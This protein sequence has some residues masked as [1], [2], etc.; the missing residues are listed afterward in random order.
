MLRPALISALALTA[1]LSGC[2]G[3]GGQGEPAPK[4]TSD[5][6]V[7]TAA[8]TD[9]LAAVPAAATLTARTVA[10]ADADLL[11]IYRK[12]HAAPE[13]SFEEAKTSA[14]LAQQM[15]SMGFE[16]TTGLGEDWVKAKATKDVGKV[17]PGVGGYGVVAVLRNGD[18]PTV[19]IRTDM[20]ALPV[21][22]Q[23]GVPFA[24]TVRA[25]TWT[26][27]NSPVMHAC[28]HDGHMSILL[29][30]AAMLL[31]TENR[32]HPIRLIFQP[33][34]EKAAGAAAMIAE[35]ALDGV[36]YIFGGHLDRMY[37][38]GSII[39][40]SGAVNASTDEFLIEIEGKGA[41]AARPQE[42]IDAIVIACSLV[43]ALQTLITRQLPPSEPAVITVGQLH[44]GTAHNV[45]A[46]KARLSGTIRAIRESVRC[47]LKASLERMANSICEAYGAKFSIKYL[48][49]SPAVVNSHQMAEVSRQVAA[50][51]YGNSNILTLGETNMGGEDFGFFLEKVAGSFVRYGAK[52]I[53]R[54]SYP[55]HSSKFD[56]DEA[57]LPLAARYL[58]GLACRSILD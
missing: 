41:H 34:E 26:G 46:P 13:L 10:P 4:A 9:A 22:E 19:L 47:Q 40:H 11:E 8:A 31:R 29:G 35:G 21:P 12:L 37:P 17:L 24:S 57:A 7:S 53:G 5:P 55:A 49:S 36:A 1:M 18:G 6:A 38:V 42:G 27:V 20:D 48:D 43:T 30:A 52:P 15:Q 39:V 32:E 44:A 50:E 45:I 23:T 51:I 16:V 14:L 33:S 25:E 56:F 28:G 2:G 3:S 58:A 54:E